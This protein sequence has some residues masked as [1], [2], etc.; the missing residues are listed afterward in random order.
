MKRLICVLFLF[1]A[2]VLIA[3]SRRNVPEIRAARAGETITV[4]GKL[5]E[6]V[7]QRE[8]Y[9][10]L[11]QRDP[12]EGALPTER[13][14]VFLAYNDDG[15]YVAGKCFHSGTDSITGGIARRDKFVESDWFWFF[16][17]PN[18]DR[19]SGFGFAVNPDGSIQDAK[20][21]QDIFED[22]DW[23]GIWEAAA[24]K[25]SGLWTFEMFIPFS[26]L[27][28][29]K[30]DVYEW[31]VNFK[32][33]ILSNAEHDYFV[34]VPKDETGFVSRFGRL[35]GMEGIRPPTRL[36]ISPYVMGKYTDAPGIAESPFKTDLRYGKNAGLDLKYGL[37][38]N[39]TLD[40]AIN[41]DFGQAEADPATV[42]LSAFETYYSEKRTFFIEGSDIFYFGA[43][44]SGGTW[45]CYWRQP[46]MFYSRRIGRQPAGS[47]VH[48]GE[49]L[50]PDASTIL[51][52]AKVSGKAGKWSVG[53][54]TAITQREYAEVD[55][56]GTRVRDPI[57]PMTYYGV[58]RGLREINDGDQGLGFMVTGVKRNQNDE[59][60]TA[61]NNNSAVVAGLDGW[62]FFGKERSWALMGQMAY[63]SVQGTEERI[64]ALQLSSN[65]YFQRPGYES[66]GLDTTR[67]RLSG[68]TG[69][70][71]LKK[72][73]GNWMA[74][75]AYGVISPGF[76]TNDL[77]YMSGT[78]VH[79][80]HI[81]VGYRWLK[82]TNWYRSIY[83]NVMTSRNFDFDGV[84]LF[85]QYY[86]ALSM[87]LPNYWA[88]YGS[89]QLTPEGMDQHATRGGPY[90][91]Y[92]GY[93]FYSLGLNTDQR[94]TI[95]FELEAMYRDTHDGTLMAGIEGGFTFKPFAS[96]RLALYSGYT[97]STSNQ[98]WLDNIE[99]AAAACGYRYIFAS[100]IRKTVEGVLR[101]DW[102][103][104]PVLSLQVYMQPFFSIGRYSNT[105][106]VT[107]AEAGTFAPY[108][109]N[110]GDPDFNYKSYRANVVLRWEYLPGSLLYLVWTHDRANYADPGNM[111]FQR[112]F[113]SLFNEPA[114]NIA[115]IKFSYMISVF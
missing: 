88:L 105:R 10:A 112:D 62:T 2:A 21:Y 40:V 55:Q 35:T 74:Q 16:L 43:N 5:Q 115:F 85:S 4:D 89:A 57:E 107:D 92:P 67:T 91:R 96:L 98:Q 12:D 7:W 58:F 15:L 49:A 69:R 106:E 72:T 108:A 109:Y 71:G 24:Q 26:Q 114:R 54:I 76:N 1:S 82:P 83:F 61:I 44:P 104:T 64:S 113:S 93:G 94:K 90:L 111:D 86:T 9:T 95:Q 100:I 87:V 11:I 38:G 25:E 23:D 34:M 20:L 13:T 46:N 79:N 66:A 8:G 78:N 32:R 70:F 3:A 30:Q 50:I 80:G 75:A 33:Y 19:Q 31:G 51:G 84:R 97:L 36:F 27:R 17:D 60:L 39:L 47:P 56:N 41:P 102:G 68:F 81:A 110:E 14:E 52:A 63:S 45:G 29:N 22:M 42:N 6:N 73:R 77:G 48:E 59:Q 65:H 101:L 99:D 18:C 53:S 28:F 103:I 37:T